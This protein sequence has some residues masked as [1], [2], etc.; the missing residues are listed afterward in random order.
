MAISLSGE[1]KKGDSLPQKK[2]AR[3][4][5]IEQPTMAQMLSRMEQAG[6]IQ[7]QQDTVDKR[8]SLI[9]LCPIAVEK[10]DQVFEVLRQ[11]NEEVLEGFDETEKRS[12]S[13]SPAMSDRQP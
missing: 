6:L 13:R 10:I 4:A 11:A 2:L 12:S 1:E 8:S 9:S 5:Q 7:R 3:F